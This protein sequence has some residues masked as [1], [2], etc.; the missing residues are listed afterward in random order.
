MIF[1]MIIGSRRTSAQKPATRLVQATVAKVH[2]L[3]LRLEQGILWLLIFHWLLLSLSSLSSIEAQVRYHLLPENML[4]RLWGSED[5]LNGWIWHFLPIILMMIMMTI[6]M[7]MQ[8][9]S[10]VM[11]M[12]YFP[13]SEHSDSVRFR[14][15]YIELV[16]NIQSYLP[17][18]LSKFANI[19]GNI[20]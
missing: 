9:G 16:Y 15:Q 8:M 2:S 3:Q 14:P 12:I 11:I 1:M 19:S 10:T 20:C 18:N 7:I 17:L 13:D 5:A 6:V 4:M